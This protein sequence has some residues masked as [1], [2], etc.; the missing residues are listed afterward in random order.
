MK[1]VFEPTPV[2]REGT[3]TFCPGCG[4]GILMRII[5]ECV[6]ELG[7]QDKTLCVL[8]VG[9]STPSWQFLKYD[10]LSVQHGRPAAAA[11][12]AK[13]VNPEKIVYAYQGDGDAASI[14]IAETLYAAIRG[15]NITVIV[16]NNTVFGMTGGQMAPTTLENQ[17]TTTSPYGRDVA[18]TGYPL[19]LPELLASIPAAKL[20]ARMAL[21]DPKHIRQ[22]KKVIRKA[23]E[24]QI[25]GVGYSFVEV[26]SNCPTNWHMSPVKCMEHIENVME[27]EFPIGIFKE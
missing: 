20:S 22:T 1:T 25:N 16:V 8:G 6:E 9:C 24:N 10:R 5:A 4:H 26:M 11:C 7:I 17:I 23:F 3:N 27:K 13:R 14:G 19:H 18:K 2:L 21:Y 15:E 12:G